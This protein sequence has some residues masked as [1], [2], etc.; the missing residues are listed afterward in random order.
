MT[1]SPGTSNDR[2]QAGGQVPQRH[3]LRHRAVG[4]QARGAARPGRVRQNPQRSTRT[5]PQH[6]GLHRQRRERSYNR[7]LSQERA[8]AVAPISRRPASRGRGSVS[9]GLGE[10]RG[11][12]RATRRRMAGRRTG[13]WRSTSSRTKSSRRPTRRTRRRRGSRV[14]HSCTL[15]RRRW[16]KRSLASRCG[17]AASR[18]ECARAECCSCTP[19]FA[20]APQPALLARAAGLTSCVGASLLFSRKLGQKPLPFEQQSLR[21]SRR[22]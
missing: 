16:P 11:R 17:G 19:R 21:A 20:R 13:A 10:R 3:P 15:R 9:Q 2:Q 1:S 4:A 8:D 18:W 22:P 14:R 7:K 12:R 6:P 5:Q